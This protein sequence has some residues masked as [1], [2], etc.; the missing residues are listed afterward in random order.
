MAGRSFT[1]HSNGV[2]N[3]IKA[4]HINELQVASEVDDARI[5]AKADAIALAAHEGDTTNPHNVT[6]FQV[7]A[8]SAGEVDAA[9]AQKAGVA[10]LADH[11][12]DTTNPHNVTKAQ[13]GLANVDN[14]SDADKPVSTAQQAAL[15]DKLDDP[16]GGL[17]GQVLTI[18]HSGREWVDPP[19]IVYPSLLLSPDGSFD[20]A[21]A[22][23][24]TIVGNV[25]LVAG[26]YG[27]AWRTTSG[28]RLEVPLAGHIDVADFT[29][30]VRCLIDAAVPD[31]TSYLFYINGADGVLFGRY[32]A[33]PGLLIAYAGSPPMIQGDFPRGQRVTVAFRY[34]DLLR[35]AYINGR[36]VASG[37]A[38]V[39]PT[40]GSQ[41]AMLI[42]S[43]SSNSADI[44]S[45]LIY[46]H[47]PTSEIVRISQLT[48]AWTMQNTAVNMALQSQP[49]ATSASMLSYFP[50][51]K[52]IAAGGTTLRTAP[53]AST[54]AI[55]TLAAGTDVHS[56][57][58]TVTASS[59]SYTLVMTALG[60]GFVPTSSLI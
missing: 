46:P 16:A 52:K 45:V 3:R 29:V 36:E 31:T 39:G 18:T 6:A 47:I 41:T 7:G 23:S 27:Q 59:V 58:Q 4:E 53:G 22:V 50:P 34:R 17:Y 42:G 35:H 38:T 33:T 57:G 54:T 44:E 20:K 30:F 8:Y 40:A 49:P 51:N 37:T 21:G 24:P 48:T 15:D 43:R 11:E 55:T 1:R 56:T 2:G 26:Q 13:V 5:D 10:D 32:G 25:P 12:A 19:G 14:T 9:L 60:Q 28:N